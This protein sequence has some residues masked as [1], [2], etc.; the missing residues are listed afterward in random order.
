[1]TNN[2]WYQFMIINCLPLDEIILYSK[3]IIPYELDIF[4]IN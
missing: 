3:N 2:Y 4:S 1:M